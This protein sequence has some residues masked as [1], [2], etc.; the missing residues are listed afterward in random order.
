[1][2]LAEP[3][4]FDGGFGVE[5]AEPILAMM[6]LKVV[7]EE[8]PV[9]EKGRKY[10]DEEKAYFWSRLASNL[11]LLP[12]DIHSDIRTRRPSA[13]LQAVLLKTF[14]KRPVW[15]L[16]GR[17]RADASFTQRHN[18]VFQGLA[19]DGA[20]IAM[21]NLWRAGYRIAAFVHDEFLIELP[22]ESNLGL[23][24]GI[25]KRIM[26]DSMNQVAPG[27]RIGV[28]S[29]VCDRWNKQARRTL[30]PDGKLTVWEAA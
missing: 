30:G 12:L 6:L 3:L 2:R 28:D 13:K 7:K 29:V 27:V 8:D 18:A 11:H 10:T 5:P 23:H 24:E 19:A 21:W 1:M 16:T 14:D 20:K 25:V 17:L 4:G 9:T 26:I 22:S 15:T